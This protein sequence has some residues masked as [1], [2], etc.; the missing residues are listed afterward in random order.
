MKKIAVRLG[1]VALL[2]IGLF[3][4]ASVA[5]ADGGTQGIYSDAGGQPIPGWV[6][7]V[8]NLDTG[9]G[10]L[11]PVYDFA[12]DP[13]LFWIP[14]V[15]LALLVWLLKNKAILGQIEWFNTRLGSRVLLVGTSLASALTVAFGAGKALS[16]EV[17]LLALAHAAAAA[18][19]YDLVKDHMLSPKR[20]DTKF[21]PPLP[22]V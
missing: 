13:R 4:C 2:V 16:A 3:I 14:P 15:F 21:P 20:Q 22:P 10:A 19:G 6:E 18:F 12:T 9:G 1:I 17:I 5:L 11:E 8:P 7:T